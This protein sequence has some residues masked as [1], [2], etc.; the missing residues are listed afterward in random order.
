MGG[1]V[2]GRVLGRIVEKNDG[3]DMDWINLSEDVDKLRA[4]MNTV[5]TFQVPCNVGKFC[6]ILE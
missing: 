2:G 6:R 5:L 1:P 3:G 4:F